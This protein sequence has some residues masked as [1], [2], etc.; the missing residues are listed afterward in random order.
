MNSVPTKEHT[1]VPALHARM[2]TAK[3]L[4]WADLLV[5]LCLLQGLLPSLA[6]AGESTAVQVFDTRVTS[7]VPLTS[8]GVC[9]HRNWTLVPEDTTDH[10][11]K[12]DLVL[13]NGK[14][15]VVLRQ[16]GRGAELYSLESNRATLRTELVGIGGA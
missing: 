5:V 7:R 9:E 16:N 14:L 3:S 8:D 10:T 13:L 11:F 4:P 15:A 12:G 2:T 1:P 6:K